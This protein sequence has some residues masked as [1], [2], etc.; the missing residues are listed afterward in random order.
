[1]AS[2]QAIATDRLRRALLAFRAAQNLLL[3]AHRRIKG[4]SAE[5]VEAFWLAPGGRIER[6]VQTAATEVVA[7][8]RVFSAAGLIASAEDRHHVTEAQRHLAESKA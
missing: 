7:A 4:Q 2:D 5:E 6:H 1:M 8:F 3:Q